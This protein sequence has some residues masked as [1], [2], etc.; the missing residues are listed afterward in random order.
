M[1]AEWGMPNTFL[2]LMPGKIQDE[3]EQ[4]KWIQALPSMT[5]G[6]TRVGAAGEGALGE[7]GAGAA[8]AGA[9]MARARPMQR[10]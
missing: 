1:E 3:Y 8:L 10:I 9:G 5:Q 6:P 4:G 2:E 7:Q